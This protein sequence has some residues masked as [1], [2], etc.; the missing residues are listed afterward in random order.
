[1]VGQRSSESVVSSRRA[2]QSSI[3]Q[4]FLVVLFVFGVLMFVVNLQQGSQIGHQAVHI[5]EFKNRHLITSHSASR[6]DYEA[7]PDEDNHDEKDES[8][9]VEEEVEEEPKHDLAG[10]NCD[11]F[12][13]PAND[14]AA[15]MVYW[16]DIPSDNTYVSPF[17]KPKEKQYITF[18]A[19]HGGWNNIRV[20]T[21][22]AKYLLIALARD[23]ASHTL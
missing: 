2:P 17:Q 7:L 8:H 1:M 4:Y 5:N 3:S 9:P 15:E 19:D 21:S 12:G 22:V 23:R 14:I 20:R 6:K 18:E 10:L 11:A 13:G 16:E